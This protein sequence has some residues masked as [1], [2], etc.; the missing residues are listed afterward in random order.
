M[1]SGFLC[2]IGNCDSIKSVLA[3]ARFFVLRGNCYGGDHS[4]DNVFLF[5]NA[6]F[7]GKGKH[8]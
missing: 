5:E 2:A 3:G 8:I 6:P 1:K 7:L 4:D